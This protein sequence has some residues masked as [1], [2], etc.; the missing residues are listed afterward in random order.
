MTE[1]A[2]EQVILE[3]EIAEGRWRVQEGLPIEGGAKSWEWNTDRD[4]RDRLQHEMLKL[5]L[6]T[7]IGSVGKAEREGIPL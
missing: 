2:D 4:E 7:G 5:N 1:Q 6:A 3:K